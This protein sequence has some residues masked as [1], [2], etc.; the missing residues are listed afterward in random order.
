M[1]SERT[2]QFTPL[3]EAEM[4]AAATVGKAMLKGMKATK[5]P[6]DAQVRA[7]IHALICIGGMNPARGGKP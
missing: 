2:A 4:D 7:A 3:S 6:F 1:T 5:L